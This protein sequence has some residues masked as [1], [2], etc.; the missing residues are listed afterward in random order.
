[1][2]ISVFAD[3]T[4]DI[5]E[6][7]LIAVSDVFKISVNL[8][9]NSMKSQYDDLSKVGFVSLRADN[10]QGKRI[11]CATRLNITYCMSQHFVSIA[12]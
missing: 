1:M 12:V 2:S 9:Q 4:I 8:L 11:V 10:T 5:P 3:E 6:D 7:T